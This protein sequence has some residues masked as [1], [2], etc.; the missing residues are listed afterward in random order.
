MSQEAEP[1]GDHEFGDAN[2]ALIRRLLE[3]LEENRREREELRRFIEE[4]TIVK[5]TRPEAKWRSFV[6][7]IIEMVRTR[8]YATSKDAEA[9][10]LCNTQWQRCLAQIVTEELSWKITTIKHVKHLHRPDFDLKD[11]KASS[12]T[13]GNCTPTDPK[14][15][16][17]LIDE[18][19]KSGRLNVLSYLQNKAPEKSEPWRDDVIDA[20]ARSIEEDDCG[21]ERELNRRGCPGDWF[22]KRAR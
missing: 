17:L 19:A 8:G 4:K 13:L 7:T 15:H 3:E 21:I 18:I 12:L 16:L 20:L 10:G 5:R 11:V 9:L 14:L 2:E 6:P 22:R 1:L